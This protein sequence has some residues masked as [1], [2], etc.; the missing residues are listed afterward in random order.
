MLQY[1]DSTGREQKSDQ[2]IVLIAL[3]IAELT[4][5]WW[6]QMHSLMFIDAAVGMVLIYFLVCCFV[7]TIIYYEQL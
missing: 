5:L 6:R 4:L 1:N 3:W 7:C 2:K